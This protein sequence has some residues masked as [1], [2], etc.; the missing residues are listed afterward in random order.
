MNQDY[1]YQQ[2]VPQEQRTMAILAHVLTFVSSFIA[3]LLIYLMTRDSNP[4]PEQYHTDDSSI[5]PQKPKE[6]FAAIH[7]K[8]SLNFQISMF[9]YLIIS[10]VLA[11]ILIGFVLIGILCLITL[12]CTIIATV[13]AANGELYRYPLCIRFI[14]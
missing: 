11:I 4:Q 7:A 1:S 10:G 9:L 2:S 12:V 14:S 3:P 6:S 8:E 5:F 13:K